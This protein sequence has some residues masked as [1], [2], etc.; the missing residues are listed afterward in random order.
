MQTTLNK[1][2]SQIYW[3]AIFLIHFFFLFFFLKNHKTIMLLEFF[4]LFG[5]KVLID[6]LTPALTLVQALRLT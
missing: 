6:F 2:A 1:E 5:L 4:I 3:T